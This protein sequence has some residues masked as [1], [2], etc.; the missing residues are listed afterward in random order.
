MD[1]YIKEYSIEEITYQEPELFFDTLENRY[2]ATLLTGKGP[3]DI[4]KSAVIG[5]SPFKREILDSLNNLWDR[6]KELHLSTNFHTYPYPINRLGAVGFISYEALHSIESVKKETVDNYSFPLAEWLIYNKY[7]Y[8]DRE[9]RRCFLIELDY[10]SIPQKFNSDQYYRDDGFSVTELVPDFTEDE[11]KSNVDAIKDAI[12]RG[13]V[14]EVNLTQSL[15]GDFS[16]SP[17][18][19]FKKLYNE[20]SAPYTAY[21][22]RDEYT[23]VSNS[24]ELFLKAYGDR[25]ETRP[26]K[27]TAPRS[28]HKSEDRRLQEELYNSEKNQAELY[29]IVDLMRNDLSRVCRVGSVEVLTEK[30]VEHY[31]NVHHLVSIIQGRLEDN[32]DY[33]DLF[34]ACF[35]GGSITGCPKV[36][37]M[38]LTEELE[39]SSRNLYTG[40]IFLMN[41]EYLN[42]S[43]VIRSAIIRDNKIT[44]NS[45]G[46]IT[47][48]SD[49]AEEYR[50]TKIKLKSIIKVLESD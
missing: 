17:Y 36:S 16:G 41:R 11:Y 24:P 46:A 39:K 26:I 20:N 35:P 32:R 42:S 4:T 34:K 47:I 6:L 23:I 22:E 5:I 15:Q 49:S 31:T 40:T 48:D 10:S 1:N 28:T 29:M 18:S 33:I 7:Y 38:T 21:L 3:S 44:L 9:N 8:F 13:I 43:I 12:I 25:V 50:E 19:L 45:G 14:Y 30:R 2:M 37:C 27:G